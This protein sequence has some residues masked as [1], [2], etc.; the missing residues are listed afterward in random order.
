VFISCVLAIHAQAPITAISGSGSCGY[1]GDNGPAAQAAVCNPQSGA[2]DGE[3]NIFFVDAGNWRIREISAS[4]TITTVVGNGTQGSSGDGGPA[5]SASIGNISQVAVATGLVCFGDLDA[6]K[7]RCVLLSN[8][9]I[10][11]YG[12]GNPVSAGDGGSFANASFHQPS[13]VAF[14]QRSNGEGIFD[15]LY[16]ADSAD[17]IVR[18]VDGSSGTIST[19]VGPGIG[20]LGD[21]GPATSASLSSPSALAI[22][23]VTGVLYIADTGNNRIRAVNLSTG[24]ITTAAGSGSAGYSGDG[25]PATSAQISSPSS[26][27]LDSSGE[28]FIGDAGNFVVRKVDVNGNISTVAGNGQSASG[29]DNVPAIQSSFVAVSG[30]AWD[31]SGLRLLVSDA[32]DRIRQVN[33]TT[34][35]TVSPNPA[36]PGAAITLT[37]TV[38]PSSESGTVGFYDGLIGGQSLLGSVALSNGQASFTWNPT[39]TGT[40]PISAAFSGGDLPSASAITDVTIQSGSTTTTLTSTPNPSATGQ[41]VTFTASVSPSAAAGT[42][43]FG[44]LG[45]ASLA[46]GVA[47]LTTSSLPAGSTVVAA[48][49]A[50]NSQYS[51]SQSASITQVVRNATTT[52]LSV[53]GGNPSSYGASLALIAALSP[54]S[55]TGSVQFF[56][57]TALLGTATLSGGFAQLAVT[58]LPVGTD[59]ITAN[60]LGDGNDTSSSSNPVQQTVNKAATTTTMSASPATSNFG[61]TVTLTAAVTPAFATGSVQFFN[62]STLLGSA[63]I[64]NNQAQITTTTLPVGTNSITASYGGDGNSL[65]STSSAVSQTVNPT[66]ATVTFSS[67]ANPSTVGVSVTLTAT[68]APSSATGTVQFLNGSTSIGSA[69]LSGGQAQISTTSLP[70]GTNSLTA[71]YS[72]DTNDASATS[73]AIQQTVNKIS[74]TTTLTTNQSTITLGA[75]V[76]L[77]A[78]ISPATATGTVQFS[79]FATNSGSSYNLGSAT[80]SGGVAILTTA[81]LVSGPNTVT[82]QYSGD[83]QN[84]SSTSAGVSEN[85]RFTSYT[86][87]ASSANSSAYGAPVTLTATIAPANNGETGSVQFFNGSVL[88]GTVTL[89]SGQAALTTSTLPVGTDSITAV[90]SGDSS[91]A[92]S[93]SAALQL[94][95]NKVSTATT[96]SSSPN[97]STYGGSVALTASVTPATATG[98]VQFYNGSALLGS[99]TLSSGQAQLATATLAPGTNSLTAVY[100]GDSY[101][102]TSTSSTVSQVVNKLNTTTSLTA[103]PTPSTYGA[104]V[105]L[106]AT[107]APSTSTGSV[108]FYSGSTL[109][110]SATV[111]SGRAQLSTTSLP[112]GIDSLTATYTGDANDS[113]STS[114]A[115][116]QTVNK[117]PTTTS[118]T[119]SPNPSSF[120]STVTL[121]ATINPASGTGSVQFFNGSASLGSASVSNGQA[122]LSITTLPV[123]AD[124]LTATYSGDSNYSG[125]SSS[126]VSETVN[127]AST[128]TTLTSSPNPSVSGSAVTLSATVTP[129]NA[130][131]SV[132]FFS[133]TASLGT[134]TISGGLAQLSTSS[135]AT[136]TDS[137][138]ATYNGDANDA[139]SI[140]AS[141]SQVVLTST[142]TTLSLSPS[143]STFGQSVTLTASVSPQSSTGSVQFFNGS[144]LLGSANLSG[145][146]AIFETTALPAGSDSLTASYSGDSTHA[147]S[148]SSAHTE[149]VNKISTSTTLSASPSSSTAGETVT[150]TAHVSQS[151]ATG[152]VTFTDS[153]TEIGIATL[154][155]G[156][157]T[158]STSSLASGTHSIRAAYSGDSN[159]NSSQSSAQ[160]YKVH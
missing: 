112:S 6:H 114:G 160:N 145:G 90:Y 153:G 43:Q 59:T 18:R 63:T 83:G 132:Q 53:S 88:L 37:A 67:S 97:P 116:S 80:V 22:S 151:T 137:L 47:T 101:N 41:P 156:T 35:L 44:S 15:D 65:T 45:S 136:G 142:T 89:S 93:T 2:V 105:A 95:V 11:G 51:S 92:N 55:A 46:N 58:I 34:T 155:N 141:V 71:A 100:S 21:G 75:S 107:V 143:S 119:S 20:A 109:L 68:V 5:T 96:L 61:Q 91:F 23:Q 64:A 149:I 85:V 118:L 28:L 62:G 117:A 16:I 24:I 29:A 146:R 38:S 79:A 129:S 139:A 125:S 131:G 33:T 128:T 123:G 14:F 113:S 150:F 82:A 103:S 66:P 104:S 60:Y 138:K 32:V 106:T 9:T 1:S 122:Q 157:A 69:T 10:E 7:I 81:N 98:S 133:G 42:V 4:G 126:A 121:T 154:S 52:T 94:T 110:G 36:N 111:A 78:T 115:V 8:G 70:V 135:L 31:T 86:N 120:G 40:F 152:T 87:L 148:S 56:N 140:S 102:A 49:Y 13:G 72:G 73:A 127:K 158:F 25:G 124:S 12:T 30:V 54:S 147:A 39:E 27:S 77:T 99:A 108:Q 19:I 159:Y 48:T 17:N 3:G 144:I 57:G 134:A 50:G 130:S 76:T 26:I 74:S 84:N